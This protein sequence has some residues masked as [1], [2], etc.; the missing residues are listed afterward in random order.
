MLQVSL[1]HDSSNGVLLG[2]GDKVHVR[3]ALS[4]CHGKYGIR[5]GTPEQVLDGVD[6]DARVLNDI[7]E[8]GYDLS[9]SPTTLSAT[10]N[11]WG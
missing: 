4:F 2:P 9:S 3:L 8:Q 5:N 11:G 6:T 10:A 7:V 1:F